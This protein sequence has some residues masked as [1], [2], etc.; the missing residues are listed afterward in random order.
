[1]CVWGTISLAFR[2]MSLG[3]LKNVGKNDS[4]YIEDVFRKGIHYFCGYFDVYVL[5]NQ[6]AHCFPWVVKCT[7]CFNHTVVAR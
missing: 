3:A 4:F 1:M 7:F 6:G 2:L 5:L